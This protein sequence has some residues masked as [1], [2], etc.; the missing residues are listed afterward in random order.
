MPHNFC[1]GYCFQIAYPRLVL[2]KYRN[3]PAHVFLRGNAYRQRRLW[4]NLFDCNTN[5]SFEN[6]LTMQQQGNPNRERQS[7]PDQ[8]TPASHDNKQ[9][10]NTTNP[11]QQGDSTPQND[12]YRRDGTHLGGSASNPDTSQTSAGTQKGGGGTGYDVDREQHEVSRQQEEMHQERDLDQIQPERTQSPQPEINPGRETPGTN[13]SQPETR[14]GTSTMG[15]SSR[16]EHNGWS[17]SS[18][19]PHSLR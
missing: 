4:H 5:V 1:E 2:R 3:K 9:E 13:P 11:A 12:D 8:L 19:D 7:R 10:K 16:S 18:W 15:I 17:Q 14:P 6:P